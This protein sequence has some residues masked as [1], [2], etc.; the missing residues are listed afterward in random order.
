MSLNYIT[1]DDFDPPIVY[2]NP[3]D[4][5]TPNPQ[6]NP[7]WYN[8]TS[9]VTGVPWHQGVSPFCDSWIKQLTKV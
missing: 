7:T 9:D 2:S 6:D 3:D 8:A 4:W 5:T 1:I